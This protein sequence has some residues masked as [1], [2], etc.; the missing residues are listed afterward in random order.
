MMLPIV[1][2]VLTRVTR[3][4]TGWNYLFKYIVVLP[5][6]LT[7]AGI[8]IQYWRPDLNVGIFVAS[9]TVAVVLANVST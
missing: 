8:I 1:L 3:F 6:N 2:Y 4:A 9:F 5:N 7:A